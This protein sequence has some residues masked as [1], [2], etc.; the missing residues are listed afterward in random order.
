MCSTNCALC[1]LLFICSIL[2]RKSWP[3]TTALASFGRTHHIQRQFQMLSGRDSRRS[4]PRLLNCPSNV[5][6]NWNYGVQDGS[7]L[8]GR[9]RGIEGKKYRST[10]GFNCDILIINP[11]VETGEGR[12][13]RIHSCA[14]EWTERRGCSITYVWD[15]CS[16]RECRR[17]GTEGVCLTEKDNAPFSFCLTD[18]CSF[19]KFSYKPRRIPW[20]LDS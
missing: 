7:S 13:L 19:Q 17:G 8:T 10:A 20:D 9:R 15:L 5:L 18:Y 11:R 14:N 16:P 1:L 4:G 3:K 2:Q 6:R 12:L